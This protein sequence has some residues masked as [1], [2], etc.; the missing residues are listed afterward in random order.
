MRHKM[1]HLPVGLAVSGAVLVLAVAAG[2]FTGGATDALGAA[3]GVGIVVLSFVSS[4]VMVAWVD[5]VDRRLLLP[6]GLMTYVL[7]ILLLGTLLY[8]ANRSGWPGL[9][10]FGWGV[11]A[12]TFGWVTTQVIWVYRSRI[13]YVDLTES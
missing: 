7:K 10:A 8:V 3:A 5:T 4:T 1:R 11:G 2:A 12:A 9:R 6:I 13:P